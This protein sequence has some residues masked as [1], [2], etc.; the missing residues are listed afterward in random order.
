MTN[1]PFLFV[2]VVIRLLPK[3]ARLWHTHVMLYNLALGK[4]LVGIID[5]ID[6]LGLYFPIVI[7][8]F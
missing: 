3:V 4:F 7:V 6:G 8:D 1:V 5:G 2:L